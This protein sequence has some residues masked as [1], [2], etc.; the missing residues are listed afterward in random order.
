MTL[1][2]VVRTLAKKIAFFTV[3]SLV[4][5]LMKRVLD[6]DSRNIER[7]R[8]RQALRETAEFVDQYM[9]LVQ[10]LPDSAA[11]LRFAVAQVEGEGLVCEFGV[12]SGRSIN[13]IA[14]M[15][16]QSTVWGFDSFEGL[17]ED[18]RDRYPKGTFE[19]RKPPTVRRNVHLVKGRFSETFPSFL[20]QHRAG[21]AFLHVDCDLYSSTRTVLE[22]FKRRIRPGTV[23]VFDEFFNYPGW[24]EGEYKAFMEFV[25]ET[26]WRFE[27]LGYCRYGEQVAVRM[28]EKTDG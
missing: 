22:A 4:F 20:Q 16:P 12:F 17:R 1:R 5:P 6:I 25:E 14:A 10:S 26:G 7:R 23:I 24:K 2:M 3:G 19:V 15:L 18:W 21:A 13:R 27:F 9:P 28:I 8:Q 11:L